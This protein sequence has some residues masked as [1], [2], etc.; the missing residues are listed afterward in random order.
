MFIVN[1]FIYL[2]VSMLPVLPIYALS[3]TQINAS[4]KYALM[5]VFSVITI[6]L[7]ASGL[8]AYLAALFSDDPFVSIWIDNVVKM[9]SI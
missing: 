7:T 1:L 6:V 4:A 5:I 3:N 8:M 2:F 9:M